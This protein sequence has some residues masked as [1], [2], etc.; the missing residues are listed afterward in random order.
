V[1]LLAI[2]VVG[3][4]CLRLV[5]GS[6]FDDGLWWAIKPGLLSSAKARYF[7]EVRA[8]G[9]NSPSV[10]SISESPELLRERN[11]FEILKHI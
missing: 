1:C 6:E 10:F 4:L 8:S 3:A 11:R 2:A 7:L 5:R 9:K